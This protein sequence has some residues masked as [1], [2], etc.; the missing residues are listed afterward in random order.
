MLVVLEE[1]SN[2]LS[3][4]PG[5][6][7]GSSKWGAVP[8]VLVAATAG[9]FAGK[10]SYQSTCAEKIMKLPNSRLADALRQRK[11]RSPLFEDGLV[12]SFDS[13]SF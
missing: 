7:K 9:Y 11:G 6:M 5:Y 8:K 3:N 4:I 10:L 13:Y 1:S 2:F 12:Y